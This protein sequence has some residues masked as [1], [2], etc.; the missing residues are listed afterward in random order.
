MQKYDTPSIVHIMKGLKGPRA[1][2][3]FAKGCGTK[4]FIKPKN[5]NGGGSIATYGILRG[6]DIA[7]KSADQY[8]YIDHGY[9]GKRHEK[10]GSE[11]WRITRNDLIHSGK[12]E[13]DW[14]R[15]NKF[16][17]ELKPWR[18]IGDYVLVVPP[19]MP[20][21]KFFGVEDWLTRTV[22]GLLVN[23]DRN[24]IICEKKVYNAPQQMKH[25][26]NQNAVGY[27]DYKTLL[28]SAWVVVAFNS[29]VVVDSLINGIPVIQ[30]Y[31]SRNIGSV[32]DVENPI[33]DRSLLKNLAYN[34]WTLEEM[35]S[36]KA[37]EELNEW[38]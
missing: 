37:W 19:S 3:A 13:H 5:Y 34:Q 24:I 11:Y 25:N 20:M 23:T 18:K 14:D 17:Y 4:T 1:C 2:R 7:M 38:G 16:K 9:F 12:G 26:F 15:F 31:Q 32:Q 22:N 28:G 6:S 33:M 29:G 8:W 30:D 27:G 21:A 35:K 36:G 10:W